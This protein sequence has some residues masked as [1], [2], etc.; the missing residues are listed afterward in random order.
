MGFQQ[1]HVYLTLV[2]GGNMAGL[3]HI[4][5]KTWAPKARAGYAG[6]NAEHG[7]AM[8]NQ[9]QMTSQWLHPPRQ[10]IHVRQEQQQH[11]TIDQIVFH[12]SKSP[13]DAMGKPASMMSTPSLLSCFATFEMARFYGSPLDHQR[14]PQE[15]EKKD[16]TSARG[17]EK[18]RQ[19]VISA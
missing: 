14:S 11:S 19:C 1:W 6:M 16:T 13:G 18:G 17:R 10:L 8:S 12:T 5:V 7:A 9:P 4:A 2:G 3:G 15:S